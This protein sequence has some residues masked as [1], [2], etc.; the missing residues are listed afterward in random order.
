MADEV[1]KVDG[2]VEQALVDKLVGEARVKAREKAEAEFAAK[3]TKEKEAAVEA[4]LVAEK[5][6][7]ELAGKHEA[8]V[9]E[10]EPYE[11]KAKAF[12]EWAEGTLKDKVKTLGEAAQKAVKALPESMSAID[13]L[14]WLNQNEELFQE[15]GDGVGTPKRPKLKP[16]G[17]LSAE[18]AGHRRLRM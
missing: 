6:W 10:L 17:K 1:K 12:D 18:D 5:K 16:G 2:Y 14:N 15:A 8:R 9:K 4:A 13:K 11:A 3:A 7:Q